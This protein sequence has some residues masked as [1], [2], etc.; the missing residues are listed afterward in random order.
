[1]LAANASL[2]C[3][4][5]D[6]F[7]IPPWDADHPRWQELDQRLP[8]DHPARRFA[9][10]VDRLDLGPLRAAYAGTGSHAYPPHLLL[11]VVLY[12]L[13]RGRPRPAD[14][15][16]DAFECE[17]VR[18]LAYGCVPARSRWYAFRDR[19]A[20]FLDVW[21]QQVMAQAQA[22]GL[23]AA[24]RGALDGSAV[25]ANASRHRLATAAAVDQRLQVLAAVGAAVPAAPRPPAPRAAAAPVLPGTEAVVVAAVAAR[26]VPGTLTVVVAAAVPAVPPTAPTGW[27]AAQPAGRHRQWR[28]YQQAQKQLTARQGHRARQRGTRRAQPVRVSLGDPEAA[29]GQDKLKVYRPLYNVQLL[30]DLDSPLVLAYDVFAQPTDAG[31]LAPLLGRAAQA[32]GHGLQELLT[33]GGYAAGPQL[34]AA[35][36]AGVTLYAPWYGDE[37]TPKQL[38]KSVFT[39]LEAEQTY[40]CPQGHRLTL[41]GHSRERRGGE[42]QERRRYQCPPT[43]CAACPLAAKC[44]RKPG[45]GRN[46]DRGP[47]D[48]AVERLR[49]R[50]ATPAAQALY[51]LRGQVVELGFADLKEHRG[52][53][54]FS[55]RGLRRARTEIGLQVLAHNLGVLQRAGTA[56]RPPLVAVTEEE[57][58]A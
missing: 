10:A 27:L 31:T 21:H 7:R 14:W 47:Y 22:A 35:E 12:Q 48:A 19:V 30:R 50:M 15:H 23:T 13:H 24:T 18:W 25:A 52:L 8:A 5:P 32:L 9:A 16:R 42:V 11:R 46:V 37:A 3:S 34:A 28:R 38:P 53:R 29:L 39:W 43:V 57:V 49:A 45:T 44:L 33:D 58:A 1:M 54:R 17:P 56:A 20:P 51:R 2:G 41:Q 26:P 40:V 4:P 36:A 55:G 6:H